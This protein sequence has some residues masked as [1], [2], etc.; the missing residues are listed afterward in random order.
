[1]HKKFFG[2]KTPLMRASRSALLTAARSLLLERACVSIIHVVLLPQITV[3]CLSLAL[4]KSTTSAVIFSFFYETF[5]CVWEAIWIL[6][7]W[8]SGL[9]LTH[10]HRWSSEAQII[11]VT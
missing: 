6:F 5:L 4:R 9:P 3:C 7:V 11:E 8:R 10:T 1:M 2:D